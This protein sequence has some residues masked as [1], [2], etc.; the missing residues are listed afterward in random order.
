M[1]DFP[2]VV[3]LIKTIKITSAQ[4]TISTPV[5]KRGIMKVKHVTLNTVAIS[6]VLTI[7]VG[8]NETV[9][10]AVPVKA[11]L[12]AAQLNVSFTCHRTNL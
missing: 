6:T 4:P 8:C 2:N 12:D 5:A 3:S 11:T 10:S 1:L 9:I 7:V